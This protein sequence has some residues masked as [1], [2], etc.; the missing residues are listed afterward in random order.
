MLMVVIS[1]SS[2]MSPAAIGQDEPA[3]RVDFSRAL[4]LYRSG[5]YADVVRLAD[6]AEQDDFR[7]D[8][9]WAVLRIRVCLETGKYEEAARSLENALG[10]FPNSIRIRWIGADV[11]R[12]VNDIKAEFRLLGEIE[13]LWNARAWQ[14]RDV[15]NQIVLGRYF[16]SRQ[17][18]AREIMTEFFGKAK[19]RNSLF[20]DTF[21][22]MLVLPVPFR[23]C[24]GLL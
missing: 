2:G 15:E 18:D 16:Q 13:K 9:S 20:A 7:F 14:F 4:Q 1:G 22:Q 3:D 6:L 12:Q 19:A 21:V 23:T 5:Q 11:S 10:K 24:W 8:E 17:R